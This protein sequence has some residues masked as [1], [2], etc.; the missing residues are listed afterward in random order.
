VDTALWKNWDDPWGWQQSLPAHA[1]SDW[2][3]PAT[4]IALDIAGGASFFP[5]YGPQWTGV[6]AERSCRLDHK[7]ICVPDGA[8]V[9]FE[10]GV[11]RLATHD[12]LHI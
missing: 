3:D 9:I 5:H 11:V 8:G 6:C 2:S 1:R 10:N 7:V 4:R 12:S